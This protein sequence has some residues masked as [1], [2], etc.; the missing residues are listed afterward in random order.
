MPVVCCGARLLVCI[1]VGVALTGC[2]PVPVPDDASVAD[3][4]VDLKADGSGVVELAIGGDRG[5]DELLIIAAQLRPRVFEAAEKP[6]R[7]AD[8]GGGRPLLRIEY[9]DVFATGRRITVPVRLPELC[10]QLTD[11]GITRLNVLLST[12]LVETQRATVPALDDQNW[13]Q[14]NDCRSAP[15]GT[16]QLRARPLGWLLQMAALVG[17]L[18]LSATVFVRRRWFV[19]HRSALI[20]V[21]VVSFVA[22]GV[23]LTR[24]IQIDHAMIAGWIPRWTGEAGVLVELVLSL[25]APAVLFVLVLALFAQPRAAQLPVT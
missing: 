11:V 4:T 24:A 21:G 13:V 14:I 15:V 5:A 20:V 3:V 12:P 23:L 18:A 7:L 19:D 1:F 17:L 16:L 2:D 10:S 22:F 8:N 25:G 6:A 9:S